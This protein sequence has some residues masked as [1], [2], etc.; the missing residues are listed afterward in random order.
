MIGFFLLLFMVEGYNVYQLVFHDLLSF[1][2]SNSLE[3]SQMENKENC[4]KSP[5]QLEEFK[6]M[7]SFFSFSWLRNRRKSSFTK[8]S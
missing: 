6:F 7:A 4:E 8:A 5:D 1:E 2:N 3:M